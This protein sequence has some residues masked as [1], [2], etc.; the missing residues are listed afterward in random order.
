MG[1]FPFQAAFSWLINK[2]DPNHFLN[3]SPSSK[4]SGLPWID[5]EFFFQL[6]EVFFFQLQKPP[7]SRAVGGYWAW[8]LSS[9]GGS[10][11]TKGNWSKPTGRF[12]FLCLVKICEQCHS[13]SIFFFG[14]HFMDFFGNCRPEKSRNHPAFCSIKG[15]FRPNSCRVRDKLTVGHPHQH[16]F[17]IKLSLWGK[18]CTRIW[19]K[20]LAN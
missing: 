14:M 7:F 20:N 4:W 12:F 13:E 9:V 17:P 15:D 18:V 5:S 6:Q 3:G 11:K 8:L 16:S 19:M 1:L 10:S 2:E